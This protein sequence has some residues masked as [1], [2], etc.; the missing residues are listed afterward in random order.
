MFLKGW[1]YLRRSGEQKKFTILFST[2]QPYVWR[3]SLGTQIQVDQVVD[4]G[5][6]KE[7]N[8]KIVGIGFANRQSVKVVNSEL[9]ALIAVLYKNAMRDVTNTTDQ[10]SL[11]NDFRKLS[12]LLFQSRNNESIDV[13]IPLISAVDMYDPIKDLLEDL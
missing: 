5:D 1:I 4:K 8:I 2:N 10:V 13:P 6:Q 7:I 3:Q 9:G 12:D 11:N